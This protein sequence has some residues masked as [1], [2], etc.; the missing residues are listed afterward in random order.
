LRFRYDEQDR[1]LDLIG[2]HPSVFG[3]VR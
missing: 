2:A 1:W 3:T